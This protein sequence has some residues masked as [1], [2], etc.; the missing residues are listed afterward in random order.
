MK[1]GCDQKVRMRWP[2]MA[3][4]VCIYDTL[5]GIDTFSRES[6]LLTLFSLLSEKGSNLTKRQECVPNVVFEREQKVTKILS[7][8][9]NMEENLSSESI[10]LKQRLSMG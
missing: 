10:R 7:P 2:T 8:L 4:L 3:F 5:R 1:E 6:T 9:S